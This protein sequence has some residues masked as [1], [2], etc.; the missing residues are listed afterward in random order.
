VFTSDPLRHYSTVDDDV[1]PTC[2]NKIEIVIRAALGNDGGLT[3][4]ATA[5]TVA[6]TLFPPS[7]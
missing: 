7:N 4:S 1:E 5:L 2:Q 3:A 6:G